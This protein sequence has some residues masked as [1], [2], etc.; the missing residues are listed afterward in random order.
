[1]TAV[2]AGR[3]LN[4]N[5]S[6]T[7]ISRMRTT[8]SSTLTITTDTTII[9]KVSF[10]VPLIW[11]RAVRGSGRL[12]VILQKTY[13][14]IYQRGSI[15]VIWQILRPNDSI[16]DSADSLDIP[17]DDPGTVFSDLVEKSTHIPIPSY[18]EPQQQV[19]IPTRISTPTPSDYQQPIAPPRPGRLRR[20]A[21]AL[22]GGPSQNT[23]VR[24]PSQP[25]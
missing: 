12:R 8:H 9:Y 24:R 13:S 10:I 20:F 15:S 23:R 21:R 1:M 18:S 4:P 7:S 14:T 22:R 16:V 2:I 17:P 19:P 3:R 25:Q 5:S 6:T 11:I